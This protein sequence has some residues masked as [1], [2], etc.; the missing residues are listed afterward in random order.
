MCAKNID[1]EAKAAEKA[2]AKAAAQE[3][4]AAKAKTKTKAKRKNVGANEFNFFFLHGEKIGIAAAVGI[5]G[6][7]LAGGAGLEKFTLT[8]EQI[9]DA[10]KKA[11][12]H[13]DE[14]KVTPQE[15]DEALVN[16][17]YGEYAKLIKSAVTVNAYE[18]PNRWE[19]SLFPDKNKRPSVKPLPVE[20]LRAVAC[21][22]AIMYKEL[23]ANNA[24][25]AMGGAAGMGGAMAG[26]PGGAMGGAGGTMGGT[27][28]ETKGRQWIAVTGSIPI[29]KQQAA[30]GDL[31]G[32]AQYLDDARDQPRYLYYELER[33]EVAPNGEVAWTKVDVLRA[34]KKENNQWNGVGSEQV[35]FSY[36]APTFS[37]YPPMAM[38]CPPMANKP[39]GEEVANLPNIPLN[40]SEQIEV[41]S[42]EL[43]RWNKLQDAMNQIDESTLLDRDPFEGAGGSAMGGGM[44]AGMGGMA[45]SGPG[46]SGGMGANGMGAGNDW[47]VNREAVAKQMLNAQTVA[48]VDYYL[49]RYFDFEVEKGKTYQYRVKLLLANPNYGVEERFVEDPTATEQKIVASEFSEPSNPAS[50]G[51]SARVFA[52]NVEAPSRPGLEPRVRM[53]SIYFDQDSATESLAQDL[54]MKLGQVANFKGKPHEPVNVAGALTMG[55]MNGMGGGAAAQ[56]SGRGGRNSKAGTVDHVS[57]ACLVDAIGGAKISGAELR[58][59]GKVMILEPNGYLQIREVK[60]D[61]RE[62]GRYDGSQGGMGF[63]TGA[64]GMMM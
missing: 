46:A 21:V 18:T 25:N 52:Q 19:Q 3:A 60:E 8:P 53:A 44:D 9:N 62:L 51:R 2:A 23:T 15:Y 38:S 61:A 40:S 34:I 35:G 58:S 55:G 1:K 24:A 26:G 12:K 6:M 63:G 22:G 13:I 43:E 50:L 5:F 49:F 45:S 31:F 14:S 56:Q 57:D 54:T 10:A 59:P 47:L 28:G 33:G 30:Y 36:H 48:S 27:G 20:N 39:F 7:M 37:S 16:Y 4:K 32:N 17:D 41:Q 29:R 64:A 11:E 42:A